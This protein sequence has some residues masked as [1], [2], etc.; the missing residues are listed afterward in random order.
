MR[1][2]LPLIAGTVAVTL[3]SL[4]CGGG[5]G[6]QPNQPVLLPASRYFPPPVGAR[7]HYQASNLTDDLFFTDG[8]EYTYDVEQNPFGSGVFFDTDE[9]ESSGQSVGPVFDGQTFAGMA[10][11]IAGDPELRQSVESAAE[12]LILPAVLTQ[13]GQEWPFTVNVGVE[14][15]EPFASEYEFSGTARLAAVEDVSVGGTTYEDSLRID[16]TFNPDLA[17]LLL[18]GITMSYW[19][20]PDTGP[21]LGVM[22]IAGVNIARVELVDA[23]LP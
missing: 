18:P 5:S 3:L 13:V 7:L 14:D 12:A 2:I 6:N 8:I 20:A 19:L 17:E 15:A 9:V 21:V 22:S 4:G 1:K 10:E 23:E 11:D 16:L